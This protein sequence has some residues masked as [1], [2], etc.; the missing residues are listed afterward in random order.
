MPTSRGTSGNGAALM[1]M[2]SPGLASALASLKLDA[3]ATKP[4]RLSAPRAPNPRRCAGS[5]AGGVGGTPV[6]FVNGRKSAD[7]SFDALNQLI[8]EER[9]L[10]RSERAAQEGPQGTLYEVITRT[11]GH[12]THSPQSQRRWPKS[13]SCARG[14]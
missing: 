14:A 13:P 5:S 10:A 3:K 9:S 6:L 2:E 8:R 11:G 4:A 1:R 12:V 7:D